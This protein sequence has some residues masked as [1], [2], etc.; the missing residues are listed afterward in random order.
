MIGGDS[1]DIG[2]E[3]IIIGLVLLFT[4]VAYQQI[5]RGGA[6]R[7]SQSVTSAKWKF[8]WNA[9]V[10]GFMYRFGKM[11]RGVRKAELQI[12]GVCTFL[13]VAT[14]GTGNLAT[15]GVGTLFRPTFI[16][17]VF[18]VGIV[19]FITRSRIDTQRINIARD[20]AIFGECVDMYIRTGYPLRKA[21]E[22]AA[23]STPHIRK[24]VG[25]C[26]RY[27]SA[28]AAKALDQLE[29]D[30]AVPEAEALVLVLQAIETSGTK[31]ALNT[32]ERESR[33]IRRL[34]DFKKKQRLTAKPMY[35]VL[36]RM[37]P[38]FAIL[39]ILGGTM[40]IKVVT[41]MN[42]LMQSSF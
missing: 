5:G 34:Q 12:I 10:S 19:I 25:R 18:G 1:I 39:G 14:A 27:W 20:L 37:F 23:L 17:V 15:E 42:S 6:G 24:Q 40:V 26:L 36:F 13:V 9:R 21:M 7:F 31:N 28:G 8:K 38:F 35:F 3:L 29:K 32:L 30:L 4:A 33:N 2:M 41:T 16:G 22:T 11:K